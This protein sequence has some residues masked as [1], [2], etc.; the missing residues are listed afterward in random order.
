M[1]LH[2]IPGSTTHILTLKS[3]NLSFILKSPIPP[4]GWPGQETGPSAWTVDHAEKQTESFSG[5]CT[6]C[7]DFGQVLYFSVLG[8]SLLFAYF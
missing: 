6:D 7:G 2:V 3:R 1:F 4:Y 8:E 5:N